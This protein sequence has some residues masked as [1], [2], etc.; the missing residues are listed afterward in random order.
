MIVR[1]VRMKFRADA[2]AKFRALFS[3]R[4]AT[5]AGFDGCVH[6]EL[7]QDAN[8]ENIFCTYSHWE[9]EA[10][11]NRYRFSEFFKDTWTRTKALFAEKAVA[12][13]VTRVE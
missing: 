12:W 1:V 5:I 3:E 13:S 8:D 9:S 4:K 6:L 2:V 11:L 10:H 7:W